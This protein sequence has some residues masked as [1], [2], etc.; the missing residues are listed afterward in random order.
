MAD[1]LVGL[2]DAKERDLAVEALRQAKHGVSV[3][4]P[5]AAG[6]S[7]KKT[8]EAMVASGA[9][10]VVLDYLADDAASV[11]LLQA[12]TDLSEGIGFVFAL[13]EGTSTSHVLMAVNEGATALLE[14]PLNPEALVNYVER[15]IRG[16]ARF[17]RLDDIGSDWEM[18]ERE[19]KS[20]QTKLAAQRK[21]I[22]YLMSTPASAQSR[23]GLVVSDSAYQRDYM[24]KLLEDHGF[25]VECAG[26]P[27]E[28]LE[29]ALRE[30]PRV[31]L[32]DLE[33]EGK[34]GVEF[35]R[36]LKIVHKFMPCHFIICTANADKMDQVMTPG[37]GVDACVLKPANESGN[38]YL[39]A[40][41]AMGLL[42]TV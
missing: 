34:N 5:P 36:D 4:P 12:A 38:Q 26:G 35:C 21:L 1:V 6:E 15:A 19:A 3:F 41:V 13:P 24:K 42:L 23:T 2:A 40:S 22:S 31:V 39:M 29:N 10:A 32:S 14:R 18:L 8:A 28:G 30:R 16:P 27:G 9:A 17:R 7:P 25:Q 33:M 11:K 20:M 37:N